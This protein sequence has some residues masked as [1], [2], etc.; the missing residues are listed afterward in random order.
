MELQRRHRIR[1]VPKTTTWTNR[2]DDV[3]SA[4]NYFVICTFDLKKATSTDYKNA[5]ADLEGL[6]LKKVMV[7]DGNKQYVIPTTTVAGTYTGQSGVAVRDYVLQK[8][9]AAFATRGFSSEI[10]VVVAENSTW[11][12]TTT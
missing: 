11:G 9:K 10:L 4:M 2:L 6:G 1:M 3:G 7:Y 8:V 5:Y 12:A